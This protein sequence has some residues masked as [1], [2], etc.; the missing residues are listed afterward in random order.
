MRV[1]PQFLPSTEAVEPIR[2]LDETGRLAPDAEAPLDPPRTLEAL[3]FMMFGRAFDARCWSMQRQ[4]RLGTFAPITGQEAAIMGSAMAVDPARDWL[5]PQYRELPA[6]LR[7]GYPVERVVLYRQGHPAGGFVP[8]GVR[9][10]PY[11]VSLAAQLPHAVGIGW[12]M[13]LQAQSGVAMVYFGDGASSEGDFHES[14]NLAGVVD[15]PVIFL[16]Q[17]NGW[18]ISTPRSIQ[19][20]GSDIASR[21]P[22]YGFPGVSVDGNDLM[23]VYLVTAQAVERARQGGGPT[24][25]E[26]HTYRMGAH[27]TADDPS[28]YVDPET[29]KGWARRDPILRVQRYLAQLGE[30]SEERDAQWRQEIEADVDD[31]FERASRFPPPRAADLYEHVFGEV[32][33]ALARQRRWHLQEAVGGDEETG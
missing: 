14:C 30:W 16:L 20:A 27:T 19:T 18:A 15:A 17:N 32:T 28:R 8:P 10:M 26:A 22:A 29:E 33:P 24:L 6:L 1:E 12:G 31:A 21:A 13:K 11:Q 7:H 9:V 5:V 25:I 23:A 2:L 4:G 3:R